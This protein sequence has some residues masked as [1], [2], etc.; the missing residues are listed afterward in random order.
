[1]RLVGEPVPAL[2]DREL[3]PGEQVE[4]VEVRRTAVSHAGDLPFV[5]DVLFV[6]MGR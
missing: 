3:S 1:V 6:D 5:R 2:G 4:G